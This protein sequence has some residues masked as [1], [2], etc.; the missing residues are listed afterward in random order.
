MP[1]KL[2]HSD[3]DDSYDEEDEEVETIS[4]PDLKDKKKKPV[5]KPNA[6]ITKNVLKAK[7][8]PLPKAKKG[9][10]IKKSKLDS[11]SESEDQSE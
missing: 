4:A 6:K 10:T 2:S 8:K 7:L 11:S 9:N 1:K 3:S 5:A